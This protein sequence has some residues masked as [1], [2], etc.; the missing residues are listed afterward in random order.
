MYSFLSSYQMLRG[1]VIVFTA[2]LS[3]IVLGH[4]TGWV[5]GVGILL[6]ILGLVINSLIW[7]LYTDIYTCLSLSY[8]YFYLIPR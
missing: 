4:R 8:F 3:F 1:S 5:R 2:A 7:L 6:V